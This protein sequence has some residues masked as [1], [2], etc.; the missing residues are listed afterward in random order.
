MDEP[1]IKTVLLFDGQLQESIFRKSIDV[2]LSITNDSKFQ[3]EM[4]FVKRIHYLNGK[5][6]IGLRTT[7]YAQNII[8]SIMIRGF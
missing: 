4:K 6:G 7:G 1:P 2:Y 3:R 5:I 8:E